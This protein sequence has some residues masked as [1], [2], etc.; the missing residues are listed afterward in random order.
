M[1]RRPFVD[2]VRGPCVDRAWTVSRVT[3][4]PTTTTTMTPPP[5]PATETA[6]ET[7]DDAPVASIDLSLA[8][9]KTHYLMRYKAC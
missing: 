4:D 1:V 9:A 6:T 5:P 7:N 8:C 2:A 3:N